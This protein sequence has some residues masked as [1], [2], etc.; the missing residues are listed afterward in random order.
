M[1]IIKLFLKNLI[2]YSVRM[3]Y[4]SIIKNKLIKTTVVLLIM[5]PAKSVTGKI[6]IKM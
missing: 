1:Y 4:D 6:V 2:I 5:D 3:I